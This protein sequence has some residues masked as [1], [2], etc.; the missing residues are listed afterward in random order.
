MSPLLHS[1]PILIND[2]E[3]GFALVAWGCGGLDEGED[4]AVGGAVAWF[5]AC[6]C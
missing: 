1:I 5:E 6:Q 3:L 2:M 4:E